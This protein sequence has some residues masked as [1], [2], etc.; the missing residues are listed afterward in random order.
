MLPNIYTYIS[1]LWCCDGDEVKIKEINS[2]H[3]DGF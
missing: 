1:K 3:E 2:Y